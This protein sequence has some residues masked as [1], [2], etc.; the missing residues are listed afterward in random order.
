MTGK[1]QQNYQNQGLPKWKRFLNSIWLVLA[2]VSFM[3]LIGV[4]FGHMEEL[5]AVQ[6]GASIEAD[7]Y[8]ENGKVY[9][10]Y[11]DENNVQHVYNLTAYDPIHEGDKITLYYTKSIDEATPRNTVTSYLLYYLIFGAIFAV[12]MW[13]LHQLTQSGHKQ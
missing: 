4:V 12:S 1:K 8:E 5:G 6:W 13:K 11:Y 7:Y 9:A 2:V 10:E 3:T